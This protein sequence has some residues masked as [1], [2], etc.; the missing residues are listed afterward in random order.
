MLQMLITCRTKSSTYVCGK[1]YTLLNPAHFSLLTFH[2]TSPRTLIYITVTPLFPQSTDI[3]VKYSDV[4]LPAV[5]PTCP[6]PLLYTDVR[7]SIKLQYE[8]EMALCSLRVLD[9]Y[10]WTRNSVKVLKLQW[11]L[12]LHCYIIRRLL[13]IPHE[14]T[15][16]RVI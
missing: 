8:T 11:P 10:E 9:K 6:G 7:H 2:P 15:H 5:H 14:V 3:V 1:K 12:I 13:L 4:S 16:L